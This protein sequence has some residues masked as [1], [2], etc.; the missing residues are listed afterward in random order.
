MTA[1]MTATVAHKKVESFATKT[2]KTDARVIESIKIGQAVRQG[3][4]YLTA[5]K[6]TKEHAKMP[7]Y[8]SDQLAPGNTMGSRHMISGDVKMFKDKDATVF[9][10]PVIV[11][12]ERFKVTHPEHAHFDM[13]AGTYQVTY[14]L[15]WQTQNRVRD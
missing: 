3:D 9:T 4:V 15:D 12:K 2:A 7:A 11:A 5:I 6:P 14:Q 1:T 13:P 10:G 8:L